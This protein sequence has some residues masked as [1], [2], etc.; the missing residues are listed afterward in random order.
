MHILAKSSNLF[1]LAGRPRLLLAPGRLFSTTCTAPSGHSRWSKIKHDKAKVDAG[2]SKIRSYISQQIKNASK[3]GGPD[4]KSNTTL[5]ALLVLA[6][7]ND[8]PKAQ[9]ER[10]IASGQGLSLSGAPLESV[11]VE[12]MQPP[13]MAGILEVET[14]NRQRALQ[15][16]R[17][18]MKEHG[19]TM[20]PCAYMFDRRGRITFEAAEDRTEETVMD[21]AI[22]AGALDV[23]V[24]EEEGFIVYT[25]P[26][27]LAAVAEAL[28][29]ALKTPA[30][31]QTLVYQAKDIISVE[32]HGLEY[33]QNLT[34]KLQAYQDVQ[35]IYVNTA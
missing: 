12:F 22:E 32:E 26:E 3:I 7:K 18:I 8:F 16:L 35:D 15:D 33:V 4:P 10:A 31:T 19:A 14:E 21:Y 11:T 1:E 25:E 20:T 5:A 24:D 23:E 9:A 13:S 29:T 27:E 30:K 6:K 17:H 34:E 28:S 2:R